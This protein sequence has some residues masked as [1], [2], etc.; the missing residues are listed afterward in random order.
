MRAG[1]NQSVMMSLSMV[2]IAALI[3]AGG[4]GYEVLFSLQRVEAGKGILA[5]IAI[6]FCAILLD[7]MIEGAGS[8]A[9]MDR[10]RPSAT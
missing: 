9:E 3:G 7:R 2:V 1:L 4:L 8:S 6:V 5:G 10:T